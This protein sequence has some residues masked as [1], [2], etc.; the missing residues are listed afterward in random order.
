NTLDLEIFR[1]AIN[2]MPRGAFRLKKIG[3]GE[4]QV[5]FLY[6]RTWKEFFLEKMPWRREQTRRAKKE[7]CDFMKPLLKI[8]SSSQGKLGAIFQ[9]IEKG[10]NL[11]SHKIC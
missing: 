4:E 6:V 7:V 1:G 5:T 9:N 3:E 11:Y 10:R 2:K 8:S